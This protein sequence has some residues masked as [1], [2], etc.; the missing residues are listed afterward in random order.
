MPAARDTSVAD[1]V[2]EVEGAGGAGR[3]RGPQGCRLSVR[4]LGC[5]RGCSMREER[6]RVARTD[7]LCRRHDSSEPGL[8]I[9]ER[10][11]SWCR[12]LLKLASPLA[13]GFDPCPNCFR[14]RSN[15]VGDCSTCQDAR[16]WVSPIP[17]L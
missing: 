5:E 13:V 15:R 16:A 1:D 2:V 11:A 9:G 3:L 8:I 12:W 6:K 4:R 17:T 10:D 7:G 14:C